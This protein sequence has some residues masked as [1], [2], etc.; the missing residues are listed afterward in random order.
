MDHTLRN[1]IEARMAEDMRTLPAD[2]WENR[3]GTY[4]VRI[5]AASADAMAMISMKPGQRRKL[6]VRMKTGNEQHTLD[7]PFLH[8]ASAGTVIYNFLLEV[9]DALTG[10]AVGDSYFGRQPSGITN[11]RAQFPTRLAAGE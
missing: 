10:K 7:M 5:I 4:I 1:W 8:P 6:V 3:L 9:A 11:R 2:Q